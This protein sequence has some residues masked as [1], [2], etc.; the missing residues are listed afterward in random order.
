MSRI[1]VSGTEDFTPE[2]IALLDE[3]RA[4]TLTERAR[5]SRTRQFDPAVNV[6]RVWRA[7]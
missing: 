3:L 7:V 6:A 2:E 5:F 4:M 1:R